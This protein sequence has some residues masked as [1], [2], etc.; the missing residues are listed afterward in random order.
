MP[1]DDEI[2]NEPEDVE[3]RALNYSAAHRYIEL[4]SLSYISINQEFA[5]GAMATGRYHCFITDP[6]YGSATF[7]INHEK[8]KWKHDHKPHWVEF[9]LIVKAIEKRGS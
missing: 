6:D 9:E 1:N 3:E 4:P 8:G 5:P 7:W 2:A